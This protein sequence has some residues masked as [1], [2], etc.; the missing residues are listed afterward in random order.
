MF[1]FPFRLE[2]AACVVCD[3]IHKRHVDVLTNAHHLLG[4]MWC[5]EGSYISGSLH[6]SLDNYASCKKDKSMSAMSLFW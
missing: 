1:H 2:I 6:K 3:G 4:P 5:N